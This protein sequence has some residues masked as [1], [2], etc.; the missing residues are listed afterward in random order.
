LPLV[1]SSSSSSS[2]PRS[3]H[4]RRPCGNRCQP[5]KTTG[6]RGPAPASNTVSASCRSDLVRSPAVAAADLSSTALECGI[7]QKLTGLTMALNQSKNST[8]SSCNS[9]ARSRRPTNLEP[10]STSKFSISRISGSA[11]NELGP[12]F[13]H[14]TAAV[15]KTARVPR[16]DRPSSKSEA[17]GVATD[18][19][20]NSR[21]L[22]ELPVQRLALPHQ[23]H[24]HSEGTCRRNRRSSPRTPSRGS[25]GR[26]L[27]RTDRQI[28]P[29]RD[30]DGGTAPQISDRSQR[31]VGQQDRPRQSLAQQADTGRGR[32]RAPSGCP[33][34]CWLTAASVGL[35][36]GA[37]VLDNYLEEVPQPNRP[38]FSSSMSLEA[39]FAMMKSYESDCAPNPG[40]QPGVRERPARVARPAARPQAAQRQHEAAAGDV[41]R[42][43]QQAASSSFVAAA[44][45]AEAASNSHGARWQRSQQSLAPERSQ[46]SEETQLDLSRRLQFAQYLSD[47]FVIK[48]GEPCLNYGLLRDKKDFQPIKK[49]NWWSSWWSRDL[50]VPGGGQRGDGGE[51][52]RRGRSARG[53][54]LPWRPI[55]RTLADKPDGRQT[56]MA[57]LLQRMVSDA[58]GQGWP[59]RCRRLQRADS[60]PRRTAAAASPRAGATFCCVPQVKREVALA[61]GGRLRWHR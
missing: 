51:R 28:D 59:R 53:L 9:Q 4:S 32:A 58:Y 34:S 55:S 6:F 13:A 18:S 21:S 45:A 40:R 20:K 54:K 11:L 41:A 23:R 39:Q 56:G 15:E 14:C 8:A 42:P 12:R 50:P 57:R 47:Y 19:N 26:P 10:S 5:R 22:N 2:G 44:A 37:A 27:S 36:A 61:D 30:R 16:C 49:F 1:S 25:R 46:I 35:V 60:R 43:Q 7:A 29:G 17:A 33:P 52:R 38:R 48:Q 24:L 31:T 3:R